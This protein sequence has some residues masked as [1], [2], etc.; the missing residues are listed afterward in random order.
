LWQ[1]IVV[2]L[3]ACVVFVLSCL[4]MPIHKRAL[5]LQ[6]STW[7]LVGSKK[8]N[9]DGIQNCP[10]FNTGFVCNKVWCTSLLNARNPQ[11]C[12]DFSVVLRLLS[13]GCFFY[14][15]MHIVHVYL[16]CY[17]IHVVYLYYIWFSHIL[18]AILY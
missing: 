12:L 10:I 2:R 5:F 13:F 15:H 3:S 7:T 17:G 14:I 16:L 6:T 1:N 9:V 11:V 18:F 4:A 8:Q